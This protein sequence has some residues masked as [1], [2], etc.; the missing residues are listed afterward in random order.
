MSVKD[1]VRE[2]RKT[3]EQITNEIAE[4]RKEVQYAVHQLK[5]TPIRNMILDEIKF[6]RPLQKIR[7]IIRGE[8]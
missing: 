4:T 8:E 2:M 5:V 6:R 1:A 3:I 7:R